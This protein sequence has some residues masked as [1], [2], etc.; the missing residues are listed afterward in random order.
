MVTLKI[1]TGDVDHDDEFCT[2]L[3]L[4]PKTGRLSRQSSLSSTLPSLAGMELA[5]SLLH[6]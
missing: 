1:V 3:P 2:I 4:P 6:K 5:D